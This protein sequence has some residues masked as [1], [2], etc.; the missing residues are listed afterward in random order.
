MYYTAHT[1]G[2]VN[3][4]RWKSIGRKV[5]QAVFVYALGPLHCSALYSFPTFDFVV[6]HKR[7]RQKCKER[8]EVKVDAQREEMC[9]NKAKP[10]ESR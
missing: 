7:A 4:S 1:V 9:C 2:S 5:Y 6:A 3:L 8:I 10:G